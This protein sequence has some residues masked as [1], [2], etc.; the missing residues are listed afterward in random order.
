M[1]VTR[2]A[3]ALARLL[4]ALEADILDAPAEDIRAALRETGRA[5]EGALHE[6]RSLLRQAEAA[7]DGHGAAMPRDGP[8]GGVGAH[9]H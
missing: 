6:I 9:R 7:E 5:R 4:D 2:P 3:A 1:A 8:G